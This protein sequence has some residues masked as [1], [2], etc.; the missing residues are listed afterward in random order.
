MSSLWQDEPIIQLALAAVALV[1]G[2]VIGGLGLFVGFVLTLIAVV[3]LGSNISPTLQIVLSLIFVQG[4]G[5]GGVAL[6]Y[7]RFRRPVVEWVRAEF[8]I[9]DRVPAFEI[10]VSVP[11]LRQVAIIGGG[12]VTALGGVI[13]ASAVI[14][15]L[16]QYT[17][18]QLDTGNNA[19]AELGMQN[20]EI[21]LLLIP[22]S[23]LIIGPGEELLFRGVVQGRIREAFSPIPGILIPSAIFAGLHWFALSG[24]SPQGNLVALAILLVPSVVFG[25]TYEYTQNIVVPAM[26]HGF[27]N[28][29]LFSMLYLVVA[30]GDQ[31]PEQTA[32]LLA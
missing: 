7:Y 18:T 29:T 13:L 11:D 25:V 26:I 12:Y 16:Q 15:F 10:P 5:C 21:L 2:L 24:G 27:Y 30:Y 17:G 14:T 32:V 9:S 22:A 23:V 3:G 8:E 4:V 19:A 28:A 6:A 31:L 1:V 20:P